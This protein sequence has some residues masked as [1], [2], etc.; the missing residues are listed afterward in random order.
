MSLDPLPWPENTD[1]IVLDEV[2]STMAEAARRAGSLNRPT[3]IIA[4]RQTAARGRRGRTWENPEGNFAATYVF[5]PG[6]NAASAAL[7]SFMAANAVFEALAMKVDR[8]RLAVK[9]PNDLLLNGGKVA[10][11]LL[12][13]T[14]RNGS[15]DW[16]SI[17]IGINLVAVPSDVRDATFPPVSL[18]GEG[19]RDCDCDEMLALLA[20]HVATE[21]RIFA[22]LGFGP[23]RENWLKKAARLGEV[24]TARTARD[25]VTGLF[26][27]VDEAGQLVLRTPKGR[28]VIPAADVYF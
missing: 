11:I 24:I 2:D 3:W 10:G 28:V 14:G 7:R 13:S 18:L 19:G 8:D 4:R 16:L 26:E 17:G 20:S 15:I 6:G 22:D 27:T 9:W 23:I 12:E 5:R 21:E 25:E 1:R